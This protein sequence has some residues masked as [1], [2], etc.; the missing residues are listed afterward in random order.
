MEQVNFFLFSLISNL[1]FSGGNSLRAVDI[2]SVLQLTQT[3]T[4]RRKLVTMY[5]LNAGY[6]SD[7][8]N[9][10]TAALQHFTCNAILVA[11]G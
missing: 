6:L 1:G 2:R 4:V 7:T 8:E 9:L 10:N 5:A 3:A 11:T